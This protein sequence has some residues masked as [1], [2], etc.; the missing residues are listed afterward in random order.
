[1]IDLFLSY[2][3][4]K[5]VEAQQARMENNLAGVASAAH[6]IKSSA[7]NVGAVE[8]QKLAAL[9]EQTAK[10][11]PGTSVATEVTALERAFVEIKPLLEAEKAKL[12]PT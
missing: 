12:K 8:V 7:G 1:M 5:I 10:G 3:G 11:A 2:V 9:A 4:G 6:A